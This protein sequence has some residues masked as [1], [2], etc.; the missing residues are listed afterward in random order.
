MPLVLVAFVGTP[1]VM[2][3]QRLSAEKIIANSVAANHKDF[4]AAINYNW[5]ERDRTP[6]GFKTSQV[7]MI[8]GTPYY[9][10]IAVNGKP[11]PPAQAAQEKKKEQQAIAERKAE[12]P[13]QRRKR[14][15]KFEQDRHR[16]AEMM[17][18]LTKAFTFTIVG[19]QK[20][21]GFD[22]WA[23]RATPCKD[24]H[25][26]TMETEVLTGMRGQLW[27]DQKTFQWVKV[28]AEV[29]RP[30]SIGGFLAKVEPGTR[31]ELEKSP[32]SDGIWLVSHFSMRSD[33]KVLHMFNRSSQDDETYSDYQ[34][35]AGK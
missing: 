16:D 14:I 17:A 26:P 21:R 11:L 15:Q 8:D 1:P 7:T 6:K 4:E 30:V 18:Q 2:H 25:P 31:F 33:A 28:V 20:L 32:V 5:K 22:V 13:E 35:I 29:V 9:R 3:A 24:Y 23:L 12:S 10:L 27:I 19:Q 34:K